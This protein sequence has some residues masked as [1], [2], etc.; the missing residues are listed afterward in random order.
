MIIGQAQIE[1]LGMKLIKGQY[2]AQPHI[3]QELLKFP[4]KDFTKVQIQQF[5]GI[6]NYL[7]DFVPRLSELTRPLSDMLKRQP[8]PWSQEKT[9]AV[10]KLKEIMQTLPPLQIHSDGKRI[11]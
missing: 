7:R 9:A 3:A 1:F 6:V 4:E 10:K 2:E 5:L 8:P 11:L